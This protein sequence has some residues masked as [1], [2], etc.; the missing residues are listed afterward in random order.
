MTVLFASDACLTIIWGAITLTRARK[1]GELATTGPYA[2]IQH[3]MYGALLWSGTATV[4]FA[5]ESWLVLTAVVPLH[6]LWIRLVQPEEE[7]LEKRFGETYRQYAK[8][9]G[10]FLPRLTGLRK[11]ASKDP[12]ETDE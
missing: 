6:P 11:A 8:E 1:K 9:T 7:E 4:A 2:L 10:Q 3:P 5:L 12:S